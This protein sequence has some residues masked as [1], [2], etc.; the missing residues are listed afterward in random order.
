MKVRR[1]YVAALIL[2]TDHFVPKEIAFNDAISL[3]V[4]LSLILE[5]K[6]E[7]KFGVVGA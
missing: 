5:S 2:L 4:L 6:A 7:I 1:D 3:I